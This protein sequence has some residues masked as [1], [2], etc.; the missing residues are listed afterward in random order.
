MIPQFEC[1][2]CRF[3]C[4]RMA[5]MISHVRFSHPFLP[6]QQFFREVKQ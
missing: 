5:P 3:K 2:Y 6:F 4:F 1:R